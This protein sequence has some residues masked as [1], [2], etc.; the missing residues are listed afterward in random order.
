LTNLFLLYNMENRL[1]RHLQPRDPQFRPAQTPSMASSSLTAQD[2]AYDK[3]IEDLVKQKQLQEEKELRYAHELKNG[4]ES[5]MKKVKEKKLKLREFSDDLKV[6]I[7]EINRRKAREV[8]YKRSPGISD[9]MHGYPSLPE[10]PDA[11]R[12]RRKKAVQEMLKADLEAQMKIQNEETQAKKRNNLILENEILERSKQE[13]EL[14]KQLRLTK[15]QQEK[16]MLSNCWERSYHVKS[17]NKTIENMRRYG[18]GGTSIEGRILETEEEYQAEHNHHQ[19][20]NNTVTL[21]SQVQSSVEKDQHKIAPLSETLAIPAAATLGNSAVV[22]SPYLQKLE[23]IM[24]SVGSTSNKNLHKLTGRQKLAAELKLKIEEDEK[25]KLQEQIKKMIE[26]ETKAITLNAKSVSPNKSAL[27]E[28]IQKEGTV[29]KAM[30]K[31]LES[32]RYNNISVSPTRQDKLNGR[33]SPFANPHPNRISIKRNLSM[34]GA[35]NVKGPN[36]FKKN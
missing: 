12:R 20:L 25:L 19:E 15:K 33:I 30:Y 4:L 21:A 5:D 9:K 27:R 23:K 14:D 26:Q 1:P 36:G 22:T 13:F 11:E 10:T 29:D 34:Y 18:I 35:Q 32:L 16:E 24:N 6:Q 3:V 17:I 2:R 8:E 31:E 28:R 7:E